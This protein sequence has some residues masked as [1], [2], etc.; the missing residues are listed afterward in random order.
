MGINWT[1]KAILAAAAAALLAVLGPAAVQAG[2][3]ST[4]IIGM[5][6][7]EVGEFAY[8]DLKTARQ[9][10]WFAQLRDQML[11]SR[12]RQFEQF[13]ASAGIDP[14]TQVDELAWGAVSPT[15]AHGEEI[16]G[17]A[18]GQFNPNSAEAYFKQQK[19]PVQQVRGY[20]LYAFGS[21]SG[22]SDIFFFFIDS[23]TAAFGQ[24]DVLEK[25]IAVRFGDEQGMLVNDKMFPM[26]NEMNG[27]GVV[28]AVLNQS[29]TRLGIQQL[30]PQAAQFEQTAAL[31]Q[32]VR[33]ML[34]NIRTS[35]DIE[36][37]FQAVCATP[38]DANTLGNLLQAGLL[39]RRYQASQSNPDLAQMLDS[40]RITPSGDRI[41]VGFTLS[42][43]QLVTLLR[44]NT[45]A[46]KM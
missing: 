29:Y 33:A 41:S 11:P 28:W 37:S 21:G 39:L 22:P 45:F 19:L 4:D 32:K 17:V 7:K 31:M 10:K 27:R 13:L 40:A 23:N 34:I 44:H 1:R 30:L 35:I 2:T 12:F 14:N 3:L 25:L 42:E 9:F 20:N 8:A 5:F 26:I 16:V 24:R 15:A 46:I 6:P 18:L 36:A 43:D 38:E